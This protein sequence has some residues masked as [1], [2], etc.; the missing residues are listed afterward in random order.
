MLKKNFISSIEGKRLNGY[1]LH[2][3]N[4]SR[5]R[6]IEETNFELY[7]KAIDGKT[8]ENPVVKGK[9]FSGRGEFYK[10]WLEIY[11]YN[12]VKFNSSKILDLSARGLD[13]NL[14]KHLSDLLPPSAH[15]MVV[16][17]NHEE[18]RKGLERGVPAPVTPLG[19]LLWKSGCTWFKDWYFAEGF[20]EGD[21]KLQGNKPL[22]KE[23]RRKD[24]LERRKELTE[25]LKKEKGEEK[26][27]AD[28]RRRAEG[29]LR[30]IARE[31]STG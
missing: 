30:D 16:Y 20:W 28:A 1:V 12:H 5:G 25:F 9:H 31:I 29:V 24:L 11:Y 3:D 26:L 21:V 27:F 13:E 8:S 18:T 15:I 2:V 17:L 4:L 23:N 22:N 14:F 19:Y 7:L 6:F 10:P